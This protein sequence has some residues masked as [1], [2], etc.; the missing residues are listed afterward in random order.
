MSKKP[1]IISV[2]RIEGAILSIRGQKVVLAEALAELYGVETRALN[3]AV[4]RNINR[5][6]PDFMFQLNKEEVMHL[7]S[8]NVISNG[9]HGGRRVAPYAFTEQGVAMLSSVLKSPRAIDV[10]IAIMHAFVRLRELLRSNEEL[11]RKLEAMES[12]YDE[13]FQI[14]FTVLEQLTEE[15]ASETKPA[16][17]FKV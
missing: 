14:V 6:P 7:K 2:K 1:E 13:Q 3:Q 17:G 9:G 5:F 12:K 8:Q 11:N 15:P 10:N 4:K 16:I